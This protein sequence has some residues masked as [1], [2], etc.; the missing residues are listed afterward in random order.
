MTG[1]EFDNKLACININS[2]V[3]KQRLFVQFFL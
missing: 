1:L 2:I 3:I